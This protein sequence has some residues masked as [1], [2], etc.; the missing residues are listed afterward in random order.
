MLC[1]LWNWC[2]KSQKLAR[3]CMGVNGQ[4]LQLHAVYEKP[5]LI[6]VTWES[7]SGTASHTR[8]IW[9]CNEIEG[10]YDKIIITIVPSYTGKKITCLLPSVLL[11]VLHTC[12]NVNG[13]KRVLW[14]YVYDTMETRY[15]ERS[16][17]E[18]TGAHQM[19]TVYRYCGWLGITC[20]VSCATQ[21]DQQR[22]KCKWI[23][24]R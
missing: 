10:P 19:H 12:N 23:T 4:P 20:S 22:H 6:Q 3:E 15:S 11:L 24:A 21:A 2:H 14:W 8:W 13:N 18:C 1:H 5:Y 17:Q 7:V 16:Q 9:T